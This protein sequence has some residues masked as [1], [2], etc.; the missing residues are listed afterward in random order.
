MKYPIYKPKIFPNTK[1]YVNDCLDSTWISSKGGYIEKFEKSFAKYLNIKY[2]TSVSNGTTALHMC[3]CALEIGK[4][5]EVIVPSFT[6]IASVNAI[7]YV[8]ANPVFIDSNQ[9]TWNLDTSLLEKSI[10]K[11]TKAILAVHL[12]GNPCDLKLLRRF[13]DKNGLYLIEDVAEALGSSFENKLLGTFGDVSSFSFFGNKTITTGEGGMVVSNKKKYIDKV[14]RLKNQGASN[15]K[16]WY[17]EIGYNYRMTNICAAIGLSQL[18]QIS[19][20]LNR[21]KDIAKLYKKELKDLPIT[22]QQIQKKGI[23]SFWLVS[24]LVKNRKDRD[25]LKKFLKRSGV[26]TRPLFF[27]AHTMP[28]FN[29]KKTFPVAKNLSNRGLNLPSFPD[30]TNNNVIEISEFIRKFFKN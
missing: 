7:K 5:D 27:P 15:K 16:Y 3:L 4:D 29:S 20:I 12:Y 8:G 2:A 26:E 17:E 25:E 19:K 21:K 14:A 9:H 23:S 10:T 18:E 28:M 22:F 6:Y 11:K 30:L 13:C 24:I 1:K